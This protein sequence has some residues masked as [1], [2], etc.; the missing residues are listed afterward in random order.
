[1][2][3]N[4]LGYNHFDIE[5]FPTI[6]F[7]SVDLSKGIN[8][9]E[10]QDFLVNFPDSQHFMLE[11][12]KEDLERIIDF[13]ARNALLLYGKNYLRRKFEDN[14]GNTL[15]TMITWEDAAYVVA[16]CK[17]GMDMWDQDLSLKKEDTCEDKLEKFKIKNQL[18]MTQEEKDKY[19]RVTPKF[20][21]SKGK[22]S[23]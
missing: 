11:N 1:M 6:Y 9:R 14:T 18:N 13:L 17:N 23:L 15:L 21:K 10:E 3:H 8:E 5:N 12:N 22:K 20:T 7:H 16:V 2:L 19:R 4:L